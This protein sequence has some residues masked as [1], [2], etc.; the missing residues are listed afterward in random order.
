[1]KKYVCSICSFIYDESAGYPEGGIAPGTRWEDVPN[2]WTCPLCGATKAD[3]Q[4]EIAKNTSCA[5]TLPVEENG[6]DELRELSF[7]EISAL[8]SN[9]S[10]GCAKQYLTEEADLFNQLSQYYERKSVPVEENQLTDLLALIQQ[11]LDSGYSNANTIANNNADRGSLRALAWGEIV[12]KIL[13][14][15]I[16]RY[17]TK[18]DSLLENT[19]VY[20]CEICGFVFILHPLY[21]VIPFRV[22]FIFL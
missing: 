12:T 4:E 20:V 2:D 18:R 8:C 16:K 22:K 15:L 10:K 7:G 21:L 3:F 17:E 13:N 1:M 5:T 6:I 11:D 9:L 14:S 19:N